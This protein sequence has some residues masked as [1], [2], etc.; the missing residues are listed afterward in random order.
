MRYLLLLL[1]FSC[2]VSSNFSSYENRSVEE[3]T[4]GV[5][6]SKAV[7]DL[8]EKI[9]PTCHTSFYIWLDTEVKKT[10]VRKFNACNWFTAR[11]LYILKS[12]CSNYPNIEL[13]KSIIKTCDNK[14]KE[15]EKDPSVIDDLFPMQDNCI[16]SNL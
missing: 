11:D 10:H 3:T 7:R 4:W 9:K 6:A 13:C 1:L 2:N 16:V 14:L 15:Y 8:E 5:R 12:K